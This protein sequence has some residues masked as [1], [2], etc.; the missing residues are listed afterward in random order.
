[1]V[2]SFTMV[3]KFQ[4]SAPCCF[5]MHMGCM[6][7]ETIFSLGFIFIHEDALL[8]FKFTCDS[9]LY[10]SHNLEMDCEEF[11]ISGFAEALHMMLI[12]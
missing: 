9:N 6:L 11:M 4:F 5:K 2:F 10:Y 8:K 12:E 3:E 7:P 1:M